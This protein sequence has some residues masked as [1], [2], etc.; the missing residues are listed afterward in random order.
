MGLMMLFNVE[1]VF[2]MWLLLLGAVVLTLTEAREQSLE[3][4]VTIWWVLFVLLVHVV[5]Y[6][7]M[8]AWIAMK[9]RRA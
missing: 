5:G 7:A 4:M 6:V 1:S 2:P 8:R 3:L 9:G